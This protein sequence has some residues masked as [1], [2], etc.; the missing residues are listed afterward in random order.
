MSKASQ[1]G[2][3]MQ[4]HKKSVQISI[5]EKDVPGSNQLMDYV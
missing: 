2:N 1:E 3:E 4:C 5:K